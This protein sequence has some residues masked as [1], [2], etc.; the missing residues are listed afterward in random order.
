M[1]ETHGPR[2]PLAAPGKPVSL[3]LGQVVATPAAL[4]V[5]HE[6]KV[7]PAALLVRH[8]GGDWGDV[9]PEDAAA[10]D[11][12]LQHGD[13]VLSAYVLAPEVRVWIITESDRS[14]TTI[15][16]PEEY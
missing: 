12:A 2:T 11:A 4:D 8:A 1:N 16:L 7:T 10:N 14:A 15:L 9:S 5:L 13:R 6:H 3:R